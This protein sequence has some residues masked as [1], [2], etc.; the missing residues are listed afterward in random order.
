MVE[1]FR[2]TDFVAA[3]AWLQRLLEE[4]VRVTLSVDDYFFGVGFSAPLT[5]IETLPSG[6][7]FDPS[8]LCG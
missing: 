4:T 8:R 6:A 1:S 7:Y 5:R 3:L 2:L